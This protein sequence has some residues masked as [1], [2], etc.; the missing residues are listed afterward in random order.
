[1]ITMKR[2]ILISTLLLSTAAQT[3]W[4]DES[5]QP[6]TVKRSLITNIPNDLKPLL[7]ENPH[8]EFLLLISEEGELLSR[9]A[10]ESNHY[11]LIEPATRMIDQATYTPAF[12]NGIAVPSR[13]QTTVHFRDMDQEFWKA[14]GAMPMGSNTMNVADKKMYERD[15]EYFSY[16][17]SEI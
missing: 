17:R 8:V 9:L 15:R 5:I 10:T 3:L 13:L 14:T 12:K 4:S 2:V 1:M 6:P 16:H 11:S 7:M